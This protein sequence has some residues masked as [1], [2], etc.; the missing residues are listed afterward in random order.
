MPAL[1]RRNWFLAVG[2]LLGDPDGW[3]ALK[4]G[5]GGSRDARHDALR[6]WHSAAHTALTG[7][8]APT[9]QRVPAW[10]RVDPTTGRL[11]E[12]VLDLSL[13]DPAEGRLVHVDWSVTC[14]HSDYAPRRHARA[15]K[16]GLAASHMVEVKRAR[17]PTGGGELVPLVFEAGGRPSD[18]AAAFIRS[19]GHE[20]ADD[21]RAAVV[22]GFWRRLSRKLQIGNA[23]IVHSVV[24]G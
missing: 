8:P 20:L 12:A 13:R 2:I 14:E 11:E 9:E 7:C 18:E 16:D 22:G 5:V 24:N 21:E 15:H 4:C 23:E 3:H 19:Y 17:Y 1:L 10:D 6:D